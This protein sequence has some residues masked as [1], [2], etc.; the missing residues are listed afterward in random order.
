VRFKIATHQGKQ[1]IVQHSIEMVFSTK[2][3]RD[4]ESLIP[5]LLH[6]MIHVYLLAVK[7]NHRENHGPIFMAY[8]SRLMQRS[9]MDVPL[10]DNTAE[11]TLADTSLKPVGVVL[12]RFMSGGKMKAV[13]AML[14]ANVLSKK[15]ADVEKIFSR[16]T[17]EKVEARIV[18]SAMWSEKF[19]RSK[20]QRVISRSTSFYLINDE[21]L[22]DLL[23][24]SEVLWT[25]NGAIVD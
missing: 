14:S 1:S 23:A 2:Y 4:R 19:Q 7:E 15:L 22:A 24:N 8:R 10:S 5:L 12:R 11:L 20:S 21:S 13:Y 18:T 17:V 25:N 6:E 16:T 3:T 9:G